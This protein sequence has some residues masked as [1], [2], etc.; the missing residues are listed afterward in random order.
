MYV[1]MY[2]EDERDRHAQRV[3]EDHRVLLDLAQI[4][5]VDLRLPRDCKIGES[6]RIQTVHLADVR[7]KM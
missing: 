6:L 3:V 7:C 5:P 4:L 2:D 1:N